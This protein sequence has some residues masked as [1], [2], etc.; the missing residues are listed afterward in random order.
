MDE[1]GCGNATKRDQQRKN[2]TLNFHCTSFS[3]QFSFSFCTTFLLI[4]RNSSGILLHFC[5]YETIFTFVLYCLVVVSH[6][7]TPISE[8]YPIPVN[9]FCMVCKAIELCCF[10]TRTHATHMHEL[11][12]YEGHRSFWSLYSHTHTQKKKYIFDTKDM[13]RVFSS[14]C[15]VLTW[16]FV[17]AYDRDIWMK[18]LEVGGGHEDIFPV[19]F[20]FVARFG[21]CIYVYV[22]EHSPDKHPRSLLFFVFVFVGFGCFCALVACIAH[23]AVWCAPI[24]PLFICFALFVYLYLCT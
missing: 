24:Q 23:H 3:S 7:L 19:K 15:F 9:H 12:V 11:N 22:V 18:S 1:D 8:F 4:R 17:W 6:S 2:V 10:P 21:Y 14:F 13:F 5:V 16:T 20:G